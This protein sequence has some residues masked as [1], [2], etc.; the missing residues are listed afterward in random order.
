[1]LKFLYQKNFCPEL[2]STPIYAKAL[3]SVCRGFNTVPSQGY[4]IRSNRFERDAIF[5]DKLAL[6]PKAHSSQQTHLDLS[7]G[8]FND[9]TGT[10]VVENDNDQGPFIL[11]SEI[12]GRGLHI[13][14]LTCG[15]GGG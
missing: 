1:M 2:H 5:G 11:R 4:R 9:P 13:Q 10:V 8:A 14:W 12:E 7:N 3:G 15:Q 6:D